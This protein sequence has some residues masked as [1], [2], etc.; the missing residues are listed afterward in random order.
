MKDIK[1]EER[2]RYLLGVDYHLNTNTNG[3]WSLYRQ[4]D[5]GEMYFSNENKPIM[6]SET[7][8]DKDLL[9]FAKQHRKYCVEVVMSGARVIIMLLAL[10][11]L[12]LNIFIFNN[13]IIRGIILGIEI[14]VVVESIL[15]SIITEHNY[16]LKTEQYKEYCD[17]AVKIAKKEMDDLLKE[18]K[19]KKKSGRKPKKE[20]KNEQ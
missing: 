9:K 19:Q 4:Y 12:V 11:L 18:T 14:I 1:N 10:A 17:L 7:H 16:D 8:T 2:I 6:T 3:E 5:N 13:N 15:Q 20:S